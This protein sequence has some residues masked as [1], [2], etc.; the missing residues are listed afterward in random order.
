MDII[1]ALI[2]SI[3]MFLV[4]LIYKKKDLFFF[5][6][7]SIVLIVFYL[8]FSTFIKDYEYYKQQPK[9][10]AFDQFTNDFKISM[11]YL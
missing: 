9:V 10:K 2:I 1:I 5:F 3:F 11:K 8:C 6:V 4:T 7:L